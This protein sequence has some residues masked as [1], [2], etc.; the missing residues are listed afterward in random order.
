MIAPRPLSVRV[1]GSLPGLGNPHQHD[2]EGEDSTQTDAKLDACFPRFPMQSWCKC[3]KIKS[4]LNYLRS[5]SRLCVLEK[6]K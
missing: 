5:P 4:F 6:R 3:K 2:R 1:G